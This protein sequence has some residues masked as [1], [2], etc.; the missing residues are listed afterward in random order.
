M[1]KEKWVSSQMIRRDFNLK[2]VIKEDFLNSFKEALK[3]KDIKC[4]RLDIVTMNDN[5]K[6]QEI[7]SLVHSK[8]D[9]EENNELLV[10]STEY[11]LM[12][13]IQKAIDSFK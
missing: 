3:C 4:M 13:N 10:D 9:Q 5:N 6:L 2:E 11:S 7:I 1:E 12:T 8:V